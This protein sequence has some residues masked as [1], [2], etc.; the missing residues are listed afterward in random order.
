MR[1]E[2]CRPEGMRAWKWR[3]PS[4]Q[5]EDDADGSVCGQREQANAEVAQAQT[6]VE[7]NLAQLP[8]GEKAIDACIEQQNFVEDGETRTPCRLKPA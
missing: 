5:S 3:K 2:H 7:A 6:E 8:D 4:T 1:T